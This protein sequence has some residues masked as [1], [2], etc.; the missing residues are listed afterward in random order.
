[1]SFSRTSLAGEIAKRLSGKQPRK[2]AKEVAAYLIEN[3]KAAELNSLERDI[4]EE[5][6]AKN[7]IIELTAISVHQL[8]SAQITNIERLVKK[9]YPNCKQVIV[10]QVL[11]ESITGG[12]RLEFANQLL[13]LSAG[14]KLNR[15]RKLTAK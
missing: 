9:L 7:G 6:G 8:E 4:M 11:D 2:L 1:M 12:V 14:A 13:D 3:N 5:R 10:D 15:L